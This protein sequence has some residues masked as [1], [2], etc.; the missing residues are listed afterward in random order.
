LKDCIQDIDIQNSK[1][2]DV[3]TT[4]PNEIF[5]TLCESKDEILDKKIVYNTFTNCFIKN[6]IKHDNIPY[7]MPKIALSLNNQLNRISHN[8]G[9][10]SSLSRFTHSE[11]R[12]KHFQQNNYYA[13]RNNKA[14]ESR[15]VYHR[16]KLEPL[17]GRVNGKEKLAQ[18]LFHMKKNIIL[19][20]DNYFNK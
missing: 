11:D 19:Y 2:S 6:N 5:L 9:K 12:D 14:K 1:E 8:Y 3:I 16:V 15:K 20:M 10:I 13:Y 4:K 17:Y 7:K 18:S